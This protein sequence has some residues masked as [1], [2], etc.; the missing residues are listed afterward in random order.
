[1][2][3]CNLAFAGSGQLY[4]AFIGVLMCLQ[5]RGISIAEIAA[6]SGG[7]IIA[8]GIGSGHV[9]GSQLVSLIKRT[10][11]F[12]NKLFDLSL[13]SLIKRW[14]LIKGDRIKSVF[15]SHFCRTLG[16]SSI[17]L[18]VSASNITARRLR[19][20]SSEK[21]PAF[22]L[23]LAVRASIS[24]PLIFAP[25]EIDGNLHV[26][27]GWMKNMPSDVFSNGLP[28]LAFNFKPRAG[29]AIGITNLKNY[30]LALL[31]SIIDGDRGEEASALIHTISISTRLSTLNF[32][33]SEYDV[34]EM[35]AEGYKATD[36]WLRKNEEKVFKMRDL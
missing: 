19:I 1:M 25:V 11:P 2:R 12:K 28:V 8:A 21:D 3:R 27:G 9:P 20:F 16:E 24:L 18:H 5:D 4:P 36:D 17:P 7:A 6:T 29:I 22:S 33:V 10:L 23:S 30:A 32:N 34:D 35:I 15:D 26:D 31:E 14:G 13:H